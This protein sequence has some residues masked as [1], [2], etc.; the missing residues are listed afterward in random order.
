MTRY[1]SDDHRPRAP[2]EEELERGMFQGDRGCAAILKERASSEEERHRCTCYA[3]SEGDLKS[4][5]EL[6]EAGERPLVPF[7]EDIIRFRYRDD[8]P[9]RYTLDGT[10]CRFYRPPL[11]ERSNARYLEPDEFPRRFD[12]R[13]REVDPWL[14]LTR[15]FPQEVASRGLMEGP[16]LERRP[17][18]TTRHLDR[19]RECY[20]L[21]CGCG[22]EMD[23]LAALEKAV[24]LSASGLG[25]ARDFVAFATGYEPE[26][27]LVRDTGRYRYRGPYKGPVYPLPDDDQIY[28]SAEWLVLCELDRS[29]ADVPVSVYGPEG[30]PLS[31]AG[32][33]GADMA[34]PGDVSYGGYKIRISSESG[35]AYQTRL[36][37]IGE[38]KR[39]LRAVIDDF[40]YGRRPAS[41][42]RDVLDGPL[43]AVS[44]PEGMESAVQEI[45]SMSDVNDI[46]RMHG[47]EYMR[48]CAGP[49]LTGRIQD[50]Q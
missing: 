17:P 12:V 33:F 35:W 24:E 25:F 41:S 44:V 30:G 40:S 49:T 29:G 27:Y 18:L 3:A 23:R 7:P 9:Y 15:R 28:F 48:R 2:S 38:I 14:L 34:M 32:L 50:R 22:T 47:R 11:C 43:K 42:Y 20:R 37:S 45:C 36:L 5:I 26:S 21:Y 31:H 13:L 1:V 8:P 46:G 16:Y 6:N 10:L 4:L 39:V 19:L